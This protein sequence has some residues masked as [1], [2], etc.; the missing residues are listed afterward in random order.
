MKGF[1]TEL[2]RRN[3]YRIAVAYAVVA[4]LLVQAASIILPTFEAPAWTMKVLITALGIGFPLALIFAWAF[5]ITPEGI[6]RADD[7]PADE[8]ITHRTGQKLVGMTIVLAVIAAGLLVF[9]LLV[10]KPVTSTTT[11]SSPMPAPPT[12]ASLPAIAEKSIAVLPF[13][14]LS[15]DKENAYFTDGVQDEILTDLAKVADLKVI[16][17][18]SVMQYRN[19]A[20][21]NLPEIAQTLKVAHVLEGSVQRA[22]NRVRVNAQLID[23]RTDAH[24]W[25]QTYDRDL[26]DVFAIQSEIAKTIADQ[27]QAKLSPREKAVLEAKPTNDL[28]AYDSYLRAQEIERN[29]VTSIGVGGNEE[30]KREIPLL[31]EAIHRDP[32]FVPALCALAH[33]HLYLYWQGADETGAHLSAAKEAIEAAALVQPDAGEVHLARGELY[34]RGSRDYDSALAEF[35]LAA[36]GLP[37]DTRVGFFIGLIERRQGKFEEAIRRFEQVIGADPRNVGTISETAVTY[38]AVRRYSQG[39]KI[40]DTALGWKPLDFGLR[41]LRADIDKDWKG[42]LGLLKALV[43]S[44]AAKGAKASDLAE[45]RFELAIKQRDYHAAEAI[46]AEHQVPEL[47]NNGFFMP[48]EWKQAIIARGLGDQAK[49]NAALLSARN[50]AAAA[51]RQRPD[52]GKALISLAEIDA[53]LGRKE[54]AVQE[55]QQATELL[56]VARDALNGADIATKL[57]GIY[58]QVESLD[59]AF[60]ELEKA[61][62]LPFEVTYGSLKLNSTWDRLRGDPRFDQI[63]ASLAP[64]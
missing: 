24:L 9:R 5:E 19:A 47:D 8:S 12:S 7:V 3:V 46:L 49:A 38:S 23:A 41:Y 43:V 55:G 16:S 15:S 45:A 31:E 1:L 18:T 59:R 42:D 37:N 53:A 20:T 52:D 2:K 25:A 17:R 44:E 61:S 58:A 21:R 4:W 34:Y 10:P 50:R 62:K 40:L 60:E 35:H 57:T 30:T 33:A 48:T 26:A 32:T 27:L 11:R 63:V 28:V 36:G 39:A 56:P 51:V 29:T 14:N 54:D 13:E 64:K 22:L 6:K